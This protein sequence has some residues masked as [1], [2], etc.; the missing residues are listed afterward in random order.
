MSS[1]SPYLPKVTTAFILVA[2]ILVS[3]ACAPNDYKTDEGLFFANNVVLYNGVYYLK[4]MPGESEVSVKGRS[5]KTVSLGT[6]DALTVNTSSVDSF[7]A[8]RGAAYHEAV[9][10]AGGIPTAYTYDD[11]TVQIMPNESEITRIMTEKMQFGFSPFCVANCTA[12]NATFA[13]GSAA[14]VCEMDGTDGKILFIPA[15]TPSG[16]TFYIIAENVNTG[17]TSKPWIEFYEE[18]VGYLNG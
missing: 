3:S 16:V 18:T 4:Y 2:V 8:E 6:Y 11:A 9:K 17:L 7:L 13:D 1:N 14:E 15:N 12:S 10:E 5:G